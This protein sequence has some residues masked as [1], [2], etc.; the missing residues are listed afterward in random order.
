MNVS[1]AQK[2]S[3]LNQRW[4]AETVRTRNHGLPPT[5]DPEAAAYACAQTEDLEQR[6]LLHANYLGSR[7]GSLGALLN[8]RQQARWILI[9]LLA[10]ALL[11]GF[12]TAL[13]VLGDGSRPVNVI[14]ALGGLI[15][16]NLLMLFI[17]LLNLLPAGASSSERGGIPGRI[18]FWLS[19]RFSGKSSYSRTE[20][21]TEH[22]SESGAE[23]RTQ[24]GA[25][26]QRESAG[27]AVSRALAELMQR[28]RSTLWCFGAITHY[29]W[30]FALMGVL[31]GLLLSLAL[32]SYTF[33]WETTIL[34]A[35]AFVEFVGVFGWL[36]DLLGFAM[37]DADAVRGSGVAEGMLATPAGG[38]ALNQP[39]SIRRAWSSWLL[40]S[41]LVYGIM[42][43]LLLALWCSQRLFSRLGRVRLQNL[44]AYT[45]LAARLRPA[46][47]A[48]GIRDQQPASLYRS[49]IGSS[50][51]PGTRSAVIIGLELEEDFSG[52]DGAPG[53]A[54]GATR[55][56]GAAGA[57]GRDSAG[58]ADSAESAGNAA[59]EPVLII[60]PVDSREQRSHALAVLT[61][62][63]PMRLLIVCNPRLSPDRGT[64]NW[65]VDASW[66]A[67][68]TRVLLPQTLV[69]DQVR[70]NSWQDSLQ[71]T[72]LSRQQIYFD[73][74]AA[75]QWVR[76]GL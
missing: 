7:D 44:P 61:D 57:A 45:A 3:M 54:V 47:E 32:R 72:G 40:G 24:R 28:S 21:R 67:L 60:Q 46:S 62:N 38:P 41:L 12:S 65:I 35:D 19:S 1:P 71:Q 37:P 26:L 58:S 15:G 9:I 49:K 53:A 27:F 33:I 75:L 52:S 36:P 56:A 18:W 73:T 5:D 70:L 16:F 64:F 63:P 66:Q 17:W 25:E 23:R 30:L 10:F 14:W 48:G 55:A 4:L 8:W 69:A 11:G 31:T 68:E 6:I 34:P 74:S 29:L 39:E 76:H 42:P 13:A 50:S 51:K 2:L 22:D 20:H 59:A 43:R